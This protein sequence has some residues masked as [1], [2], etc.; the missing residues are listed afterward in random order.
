MTDHE[1]IDLQQAAIDRYSAEIKGISATLEKG[2]RQEGNA[3]IT[4]DVF[5]NVFLPF[6]S[7]EHNTYSV[8][9]GNWI[10]VASGYNQTGGQ[11]KEVDVI[12]T[13]GNLLFSVPPIY[14]RSALKP[15]KLS[16]TIALPQLFEQAVVLGSIK[17][18]LRDKQHRHI[19][20]ALL[21]KMNNPNS[22]AR[23]YLLRWN[24][25]FVRYNR[26]SIFQDEKNITDI[27]FDGTTSHEYEI[28]EL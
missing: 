16:D 12:D 8:G 24:N 15:V 13:N 4:E 25:I 28:E 10:T 9:L 6:F 26:E 7:G 23:E 22:N 1:L 5:V 2:V 14:D 11:F 3:R 20:E 17:P 18:S 19:F 27:S 21:N